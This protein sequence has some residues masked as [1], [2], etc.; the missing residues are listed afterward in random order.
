MNDVTVR[1]VEKAQTSR[2][3][4]LLKLPS[5]PFTLFLLLFGLISCGS[6]STPDP[7][8]T[9]FNPYFPSAD[10]ETK[11]VSIILPG[12]TEPSTVT[13]FVMDGDYVFEGDLIVGKVGDETALKTQ[14]AFTPQKDDLWPNGVIPYKI[15][16]VFSEAQKKLIYEALDH[17][18][19]N[20]NISFINVNDLSLKTPNDY[21]V[22]VPDATRCNSWVGR[23]NGGRRDIKLQPK[24]DKTSIIHELGHAIGIL[25]EQTRS[26]R[27]TYITVT[28]GN[29][30]AGFA[31]NFDKRTPDK[32]KDLG[33]YNYDS[34]MHYSSKA[35]SRDF[36]CEVITPKDPKITKETLGSNK[37]LDDGDIA[38]TNEMYP[39]FENRQKLSS[40]SKTT[41]DSYGLSVAISG[42]YAIVGSPD[43]GEGSESP[44]LA[45]IYER[46]LITV[47]NGRSTYT[48]Y[49]ENWKEVKKLSSIDATNNSYFGYSVAISG[50]YALVGSPSSNPELAGAAYIFKR[51]ATGDW[52]QMK[53]L[54]SGAFGDNYARSIALFG[55]YA[56]VGA[57]GKNAA[58]LYKRSGNDWTLAKE[59][60]P[61]GSDNRNSGP[62]RVALSNNF[63]MVGEPV[64]ST[65]A[66]G[67]VYVYQRTGTEWKQMKSLSPSDAA[68]GVSQ[69]NGFGFSVSVSGNYA[70]VGSSLSLREGAAY[71]FQYSEKD[72]DWKEIKKLIGSGE[73]SGN[74]FGFNV[75]ISGDYALVGALDLRTAY[76][77]KR[78]GSDWEEIKTFTLGDSETNLIFSR[79]IAL[80]GSFAIVG[81]PTSDVTGTAYIYCNSQIADDPTNNGGDP[82]K[83]SKPTN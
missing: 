63:A 70:I 17:W 44:G 79:A 39:I 51:G 71:I 72:K 60:S 36:C 40:D 33:P 24:C 73:K 10:T 61:E 47:P 16:G 1:P 82:S 13:V 57:S 32:V 35:G 28:T 83:C 54:A 12:E 42:D 21:V 55:D 22:F 56:L 2:S 20:T 23:G 50:D 69:V 31:N 5:L 7:A 4:N 48:Y 81:A 58:Y 19:T 45:Y 67:S 64:N 77:Y 6:P 27:D 65:S 75:S 52:T 53:K 74:R 59:L 66:S 68:S 49:E 76:L 26:D 80:S 9:S 43:F 29:I 30:M 34:L 37:E 78:R 14:A 11:E 18:S 3:S 46:P 15:E 62:Q 41:T 38:A 8:E 25:H